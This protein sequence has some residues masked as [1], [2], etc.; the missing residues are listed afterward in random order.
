MNVLL[1]GAS[2]F[3]GRNVAAALARAGHRVRPLSRRHGA[4]M[5]R[6]LRPAD[7]RT[8]LDDIDAVVNC[9]GI[10][11]ETRAQGFA[12][13]HTLAPIALFQA[14]VSA[15]IRR[16]IQVSA[17]GADETAFS[18]YHLSKR[19][20]DDHLRAL[21]LDWLVLR[22]SLV[23]GLGGASSALFLRLARLPLIPVIGDGRQRLQPVHVGDV[24]AA[25]LCGLTAPGRQTID[26]AGA[27]TFAFDEWLQH[28]RQA[29]GL[30]RGR[31]LRVPLAAA[32]ALVRLGRPFSPMARPENLLML[33][34]NYHADTLPLARL[35][36]RPPA[37]F[38][39]HRFLPGS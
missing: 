12:P 38:A 25:I 23:H 33:N 24:A 30:P 3:I 15:G 6:M 7:W 13:L 2:G 21:D 27:Q 37:P 39:P 18:A 26:V 17:L 4:D 31:V 16:V 28:L 10:I 11:G 5:G 1:T 14:C 29:Q 9:V 35:I 32:L 34:A 8:P 36:G 19:A 22:P 20:A